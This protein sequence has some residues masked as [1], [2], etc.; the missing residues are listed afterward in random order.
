[1]GNFKEDIARVK[2]FVFD[3]DGVFTDGSITPTADGDFL[4]TY[5]AQ[6]G[7]AVAYA[8]QQGFRVC[9]ISGGRGELLKRRF[10]ML[11]VEDTYFNCADK[12]KA[13][14]EFLAKYNLD[15][16]EVIYMGDDVPD[17][18]VMRRVGIPV[19]PSDA[20]SDVLE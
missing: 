7:Y 8:I 3:V 15:P 11:K 20:C 6:D 19:C 5:Y 12:E 14:D 17:L 16:E 10:E 1:M 4:R 9:V 2:A 18:G 13:L